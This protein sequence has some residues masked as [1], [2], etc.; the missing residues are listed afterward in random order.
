MHSSILILCPIDLSL[1]RKYKQKAKGAEKKNWLSPEGMGLYAS[2]ILK[3]IPEQHH[4]ASWIGG[5]A[6]LYTIRE[7]T[8]KPIGH[9]PTTYNLQPT[10]NYWLK[11]PNDIYCDTKKIAGIL[12]ET[13]LDKN[14]KINGAIIGIGINVNT[15]RE[16]LKNLD[17]PATS[18]LA[19]TGNFVEIKSTTEILLSHLNKL[20]DMVLSENTQALFRLWRKENALIGNSVEILLDNDNILHAKVIDIE[21]SGKLVVIDNDA[22]IHKI[23]SGDV[24]IRSFLFNHES[25]QFY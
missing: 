17:K 2:F 3:G 25:H 20:Y 14:N 8:Q 4:R 12:C 9:Q 11:W 19:E 1:L 6:A 22:K 5:L 18:I 7:I 10:T 23:Y 15:T 21:A 13:V 24:S 16:E